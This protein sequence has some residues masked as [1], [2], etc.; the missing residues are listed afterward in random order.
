MKGIILQ[1]LN[2]KNRNVNT[3]LGLLLQGLCQY[4][5][6]LDLPKCYSMLFFF[7]TYPMTSVVDALRDLR[8]LSSKLS[9]IS[10]DHCRLGFQQLS[11]GQICGPWER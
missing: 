6:A 9:R 7:I 11:K 10:S 8:S 2:D 4:F 1:K 5:S 3:E